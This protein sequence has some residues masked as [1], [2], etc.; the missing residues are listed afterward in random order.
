M[1]GKRLFDFFNY[2]W[3]RG[4]KKENAKKTLGNSNSTGILSFE[5]AVKEKSC[6]NKNEASLSMNVKKTMDSEY[7]NEDSMEKIVSDDKED[8]KVLCSDRERKRECDSSKRTKVAGCDGST[9][10]RWKCPLLEEI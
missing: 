4:N 8:L 10:I 1:C 2:V 6:T 9:G 3:W 5:A 7:M